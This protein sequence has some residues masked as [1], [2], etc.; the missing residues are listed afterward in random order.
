MSLNNSD[1]WDAHTWIPEAA[2]AFESSIVAHERALQQAQKLELR[3]P[4]SGYILNPNV[5]RLEGAYLPAHASVFRV[6]D[7]RRMKIV[8][9]LTE[10]Q[11]QLVEVGSAVYG[12]WQATGRSFQTRIEVLPRRKT[13]RE[14]YHPGMLT[15][16]GGPAP[17]EA[18]EEREM[19]SPQFSIYLAEALLPDSE[20]FGREGM[21]VRTH[22][23][24]R[25]T[26]LGARFWRGLLNFWNA[27]S[28]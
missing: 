23:E 9:P 6:G 5:E 22:I 11:A 2:A 7:S 21:R 13:H 28:S 18:P 1:A 25:E 17:P 19:D 24:G 4:I 26:T 15:F 27:G 3:S 10:D 14:E 8:I 12:R 16:H 20:D